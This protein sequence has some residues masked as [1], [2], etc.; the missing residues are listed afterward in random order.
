MNAI[1]G[2][3]P[4]TP[5]A[6]E[7]APVGIADLD[8][9][10]P[11]VV[12]PFDDG[13]GDGPSAWSILVRLHGQ[14]IGLVA[15]SA[16][17]IRDMSVAEMVRERLR[18]AI[19]AHLLSDGVPAMSDL[20]AA[21]PSKRRPAACI[22]RRRELHASAPLISVV[23]PTRDRPQEIVRC[24]EALVQLDYPN[25]E[26][27]V[28]DNST[29]STATRTALEGW[30]AVEPRLRYVVQS[31]PG[32]SRARNTGAIAARGEYIAYV[33]DDV[34]IDRGWLTEIALEFAS[35]PDVGCVTGSI[36]PA[37][38]ET[39]PQLWLEEIGGFSKGFA[40]REFTLQHPETLGPMFLFAAGMFGS[41]ANMAFRRS[42]LLAAGGFDPDLGGGTRVGGG[43]DLSA[44]VAVLTAGHRIVYQPAAV[45][46][47]WHHRSL[48][49][50][51]RQMRGYGRGLAAHLLKTAVE[52]PGLAGHFVRRSP[53][54]LVHLARSRV[55]RSS[56]SSQRKTY[57]RSLDLQ[58][59]L[60]LAE[61]TALYLVE[62][63][64]WRPRHAEG[65]VS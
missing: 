43:E 52:H 2:F 22:V 30:L 5:Q 29:D 61:G 27:V 20:A 32:T 26:I 31:V 36:L 12:R 3:A 1:S 25:F 39:A 48:T 40:R 18:P 54:A 21:R 46:R 42:A 9:D 17:E 28:V 60:G 24:L 41:G 53:P 35:R 59:W 8:L 10:G 13:P 49:A 47:H 11:A 33:D 44:F 14:P 34:W 4:P 62:R 57:P 37:Q 50:L 15:A 58:W 55:V 7:P 56:G 38:L 23:V 6:G 51:R 19:S 65:A 64:P 63:V 45:V 16:A